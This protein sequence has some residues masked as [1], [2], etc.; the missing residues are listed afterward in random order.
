MDAVVPVRDGPSVL[1]PRRSRRIRRP[2]PVV[3]AARRA[4]TEEAHGSFLHL[5]RSLERRGIG[6]RQR[7]RARLAQRTLA[8]HRRRDHVRVRARVPFE[9]AVGMW[10][11]ERDGGRGVGGCGQG[12]AQKARVVTGVRAADVVLRTIPVPQTPHRETA[13]SENEAPGVELKKAVGVVAALRHAVRRT[14]GGRAPIIFAE[15][16][17]GDGRRAAVL[18][19]H[20]GPPAHLSLRAVDVH[21]VAISVAACRH[22]RQTAALETVL[23]EVLARALVAAADHHPVGHRHVAA[24]VDETRNAL[25]VR[26]QFE[27]VA[28]DQRAPLQVVMARIDVVVVVVAVVAHDHLSRDFHRGACRMVHGTTA[29]MKRAHRGCFA[30]K[31]AEVRISRHARRAFISPYIFDRQVKARKVC[32]RG[33]TRKERG[34]TRLA[35]K[36]QTD[37][38]RCW[39]LHRVRPGRAFIEIDLHRPAPSAVVPFRNRRV[40]DLAAV[41]RRLVVADALCLRDRKRGRASEGIV[42]PQRS[43]AACPRLVAGYAHGRL[44]VDSARAGQCEAARAERQD[45]GRLDRG[46][47]RTVG[48]HEAAELRVCG[49]SVRRAVRRHVHHAH[50][51]AAGQRAAV[52]VAGRRQVRRRGR[53]RTRERD[54][55]RARHQCRHH[56]A[57]KGNLSHLHSAPSF[58]A[59]HLRGTQT[60]PDYNYTWR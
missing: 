29:H 22:N 35:G 14:R 52:P 21:A 10:Q 30:R 4:R 37:L 38:Q 9:A 6:E 39:H 46:H 1:N 48:D 27:K 7:P 57:H 31:E 13:L 3:A 16:H 53:V 40:D 54:L 43:R 47:A 32:R 25:A 20:A 24:I 44:E 18:L 50:V 5:D 11:L 60:S 15:H 58:D 41:A 45:M 33:Y 8:E 42:C 59:H 56:C 36:E 26:A 23:G 12:A 17:A 49:E 28:D 34:E 19:V 2:L 55:R 51:A